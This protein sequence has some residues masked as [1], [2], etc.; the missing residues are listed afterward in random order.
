[1]S[2]NVHTAIQSY[3]TWVS[4]SA[5]KCTAQCYKYKDIPNKKVLSLFPNNV[6]KNVSINIVF[7]NVKGVLFKF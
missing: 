7:F 2:E 1:M 5:M 6:T 3:C 4:N